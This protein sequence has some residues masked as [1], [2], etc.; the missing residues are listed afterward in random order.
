MAPLGATP[1]P[2]CK[3]QTELLDNIVLGSSIVKVVKPEY[4]T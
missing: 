2:L 4:G 3:E 1:K